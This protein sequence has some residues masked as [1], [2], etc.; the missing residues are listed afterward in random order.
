MDQVLPEGISPTGVDRDFEKKINY[1]IKTEKPA[2]GNIKA[3]Y[4]NSKA[5]SKSHGYDVAHEGEKVILKA[6]AGY[7]ITAAYNGKDKKT[8]LSKDA[9]GDYYLVVP[10]GGGVYLSAKVKKVPTKT[11]TVNTAVVRAK[12]LDA[13]VK[14]AGGNKDSVTTIVLGKK[15]KKIKKGAFKKYKKAKTL[16]VK[17]KKLKKSKVKKSLKGSKITKIKVKVGK[18][19]VNKKY[20]KKYKKIF[21]KKNV[22]KKVKVTL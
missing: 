1:I 17:T 15:V 22:G 9:N 5:L 2:G 16:V 10:K 19:K 3:M 18:K 6:D 7:Q 4:A 13:A 21:T 14:K 11:V 8:A 20:V 12:T